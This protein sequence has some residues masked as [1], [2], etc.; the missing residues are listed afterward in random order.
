MSLAKTERAALADLFVE[1]GPDQPT[2]CEGWQT[3]D[4]LVH[5]LVRERSPMGAIG[6]QVSALHGFTDKAAADYARQPW[7]EL[8]ELYRSGAPAW[9]PTG[10]GKL[11]ELTNNGEMFIHHEDARRGQPDWAPRSLDDATSKVLA[12]MVDSGLSKLALRHATVGVTAELPD[13][14]VTLKKAPEAGSTVTLVGEPGEVVLWISGRDAARVEFRGDDEAVA[15]LRNVRRGAWSGA[16]RSGR[17][18]VAGP[19]PACRCGDA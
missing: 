10:W 5:L 13:R 11:D 7:P 2:L 9:N 15:A 8:I 17:R 16:R 14:T 19:R 3:R 4:L 1:L 18:V 12:D 6:N